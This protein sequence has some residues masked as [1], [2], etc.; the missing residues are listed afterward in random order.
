LRKVQSST[1]A[2]RERER[3]REREQSVFL[4]LTNLL[5]MLRSTGI[6]GFAVVG[7]LSWWSN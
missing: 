1:A 2:G 4:T 7:D 6:G 3:E 5:I